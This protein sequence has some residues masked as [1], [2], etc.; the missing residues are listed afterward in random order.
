MSADLKQ[1]DSQDQ[2]RRKF[3]LFV[4]NTRLKFCGFDFLYILLYLGNLTFDTTADDLKKFF[5]D[6]SKI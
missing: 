3:I 6:T 2:N 4:G 5:E 1:E